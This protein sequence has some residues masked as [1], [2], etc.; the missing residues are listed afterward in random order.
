M[1][2]DAD[3]IGDVTD[4][5][6]PPIFR[7]QDLKAIVRAWP[8]LNTYQP[9]AWNEDIQHALDLLATTDTADSI[10]ALFQ[11]EDFIWWV[12]Q[13]IEKFKRRWA[14]SKKEAHRER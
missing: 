1:S 3:D 8:E 11:S 9:L 4:F 5:E 2:D 6:H 7:P 14:E 10:D 13:Y 12:S